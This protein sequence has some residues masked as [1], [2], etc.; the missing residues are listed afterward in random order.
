M[1]AAPPARMVATAPHLE[2]GTVC[3]PGSELGQGLCTVQSQLTAAAHTPTNVDHFGGEGGAPD[4]GKHSN[5]TGTDM[6]LFKVYSNILSTYTF[7]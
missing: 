5:T 4:I 3:V 1:C 6:T 7:K 2:L